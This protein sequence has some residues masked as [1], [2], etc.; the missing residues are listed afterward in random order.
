[1]K[2][3]RECTYHTLQAFRD[4]ST[5]NVRTHYLLHR[6]VPENFTSSV[7]CSETKNTVQ[8]ICVPKDWKC[9]QHVKAIGIFIYALPP[10]AANSMQVVTV[11]QHTLIASEMENWF[12]KNEVLA[13]MWQLGDVL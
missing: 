12:L 2:P 1:M 11:T 9:S 6:V 5:L 10:A 7:L 8:C 3:L 4:V 13:W